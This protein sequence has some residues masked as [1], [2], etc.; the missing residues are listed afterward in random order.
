MK[1]CKKKL[2]YYIGRH[3]NECAKIYKANWYLKHKEKHAAKSKNYYVTHK[4]EMNKA[5][6]EWCINNPDR[7]KEIINKSHHKNKHKHGSAACAKRHAAKLKRTLPGLTK[8]QY[9]TIKMYYMHAKAVSNAL[10]VPFEVDH[11]VPLQGK[12]V[13]GLHVP[14]NLQVILAQENRSKG[15]S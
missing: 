4:N 9:K 8:E 7:R 6:R 11:I 13:S 12:N 1:L 3:C 14:W 2:H 15:N 5:A 10:G